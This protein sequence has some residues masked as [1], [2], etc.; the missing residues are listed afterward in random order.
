MD[1]GSAVIEAINNSELKDVKVKMFGYDNCFVEQGNIQELEEKHKLKK[2][3][4]IKEIL[5]K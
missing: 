4:I 1:F 3:N 2:E 5:G